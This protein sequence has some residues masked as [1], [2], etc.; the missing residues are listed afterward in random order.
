MDTEDQQNCVVFKKL[1]NINS[2]HPICNI[3]TYYKRQI[4]ITARGSMC[5]DI[6]G[7]IF[8]NNK[9]RKTK[10]FWSRKEN[11]QYSGLVMP[12]I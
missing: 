3:F 11:A 2:I 9:E 1:Q 8:S 12:Y 4:D 10:F 5:D 6:A 7:Q